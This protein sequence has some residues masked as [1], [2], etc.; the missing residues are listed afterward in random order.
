M[1]VKFK[2][3]TGYGCDN[4]EIIEIPDGTTDEDIEKECQQWVWENI[5]GHWEKVD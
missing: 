4:E 1:K 5:D 2:V 3:S